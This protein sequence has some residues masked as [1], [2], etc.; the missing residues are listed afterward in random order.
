MKEKLHELETF[1]ELL[2]QQV[3][4]LQTYFDACANAVTKGFEPYQKEC[5]FPSPIWTET[6]SLLDSDENANDDDFEDSLDKTQTASTF[7]QDV[8]KN[9]LGKTSLIISTD[10]D[11]WTLNSSF[12]LEFDRL[13]LNDHAAMAIDF[14]GE[15]KAIVS[16]RVDA[17]ASVL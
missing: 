2:A 11:H 12:V 4:T 5:S 1:R 9:L 14:K 16:P 7:Q 10:D 8:E 17:D 15:G 13:A 6:N 3:A